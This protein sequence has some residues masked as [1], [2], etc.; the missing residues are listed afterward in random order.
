MGGGSSAKLTWERSG[1]GP[2][3]VVIFTGIVSA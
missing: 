3:D 1:F 2:T